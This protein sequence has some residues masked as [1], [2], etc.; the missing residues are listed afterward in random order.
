MRAVPDL[1]RDEQH[2]GRSRVDGGHT[3]NGVDRAAL[4]DADTSQG[5]ERVAIRLH[6]W[7]FA[8]ALIAVPA[9]TPTPLA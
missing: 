3:E 2:N 7:L 1:T 6:L 4:G 8:H 5:T 9:G